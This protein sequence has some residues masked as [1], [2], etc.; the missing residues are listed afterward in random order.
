[1]EKEERGEEKNEGRDR[2]GRRNKMLELERKEY[3]GMLYI[4]LY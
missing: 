4:R 1:M 2:E 3:S